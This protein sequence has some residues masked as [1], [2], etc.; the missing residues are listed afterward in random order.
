MTDQSLQQTVDQFLA[1][2]RALGRKYHSEEREL[3]LLI[4]FATEHD[5]RRLV[6]LTPALLEQFLGSRA[7]SQPRSL[8]HLRGA[9]GRL[10]DWAVTSS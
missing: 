8:N 9:V 4:V 2:K 3:R 10:P 5:A 6:D 7:R 1:H